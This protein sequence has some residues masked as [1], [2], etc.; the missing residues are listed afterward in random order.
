MFV[1]GR[2]SPHPENSRPTCA[3]PPLAPARRDRP[4][5]R[6]EARCGLRRL[7][8]QSQHYVWHGRPAIVHSAVGTAPRRPPLEARRPVV[9]LAAP[10]PAPAPADRSA[11][12]PRTAS[13]SPSPAAAAAAAAAADEAQRRQRLTG[14]PLLLFPLSSFLLPPSPFRRLPPVAPRARAAQT[15]SESL[16][17]RG[18]GPSTIRVAHPSESLADIGGADRIRGTRATS[19]KSRSSIRVA[20]PSESPIRPSRWRRP[21]LIAVRATPGRAGRA[22]RLARSPARAAR[23][24]SARTPHLPLPSHAAAFRKEPPRPCPCRSP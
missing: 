22:G 8:D 1:T 11:C 16:A 7:R 15:P 3:K 23:A 4:T 17:T 18:R 10:A 21:S 24:R 14:L 19:I 13:S 20:H 2:N 6:P 9:T 5:P 12:P